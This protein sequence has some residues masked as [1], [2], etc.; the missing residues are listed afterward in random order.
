[1]L[2]MLLA[3]NFVAIPLVVL[4]S[5]YPDTSDN[6]FIIL[7]MLDIFIYSP[8]AVYGGFALGIKI[9]EWGNK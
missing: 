1:M 9:E 2:G 5:L 4:I 3:L 7:L 6:L 8:I